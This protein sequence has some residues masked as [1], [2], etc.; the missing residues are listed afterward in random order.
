MRELNPSLLHSATPSLLPL[1]PGVRKC[2]IKAA[3]RSRKIRPIFCPLYRGLR[4]E[5]HVS[6]DAPNG[7][8]FSSC[9]LFRPLVGLCASTWI[10]SALSFHAREAVSATILERFSLPYIESK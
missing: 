3:S 2:S 1:P 6:R 9:I 5:R 8:I 10:E 4:I 7:R